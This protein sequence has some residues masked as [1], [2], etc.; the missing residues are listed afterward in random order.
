MEMI[1]PTVLQEKDDKKIRNGNVALD[2]V[3]H[4]LNFHHRGH[5]QVRENQYVKNEHE[6]G[7]FSQYAIEYRLNGY[8]HRML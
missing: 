3:C 8:L 1:F 6:F 4:A 7:V 5:P 2:A